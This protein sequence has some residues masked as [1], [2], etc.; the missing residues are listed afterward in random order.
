MWWS[1]IRKDVMD[2]VRLTGQAGCL[3]GILQEGT[4]LPSR[5]DRLTGQ[6]NVKIFSG[7]GKQLVCQ[8]SGAHL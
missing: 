6:V 8:V 3:N 1:T 4:R 5:G 7:A 2:Y